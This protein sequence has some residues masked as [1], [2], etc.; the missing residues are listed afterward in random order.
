MFRTAGA[1]G[2]PGLSVGCFLLPHPRTLMSAIA[3]IARRIA[4]FAN[5][6]SLFERQYSKSDVVD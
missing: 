2:A 3:I 1:L 5:D 6:V 4:L